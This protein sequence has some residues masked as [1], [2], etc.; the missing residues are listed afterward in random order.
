M[1]LL[2][3]VGVFGGGWYIGSS[4]EKVIKTVLVLGAA[5]FI[6]LKVYEAKK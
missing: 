4:S 3:L 6:G 5:G 1:P 2:L